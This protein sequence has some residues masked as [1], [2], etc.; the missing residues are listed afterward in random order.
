MTVVYIAGPFR[1]GTAWGIEQHIRKAEGLA[2]QVAQLGAMPMCPHTNTRFF[3]G[4]LTEQFWLD[5]TIE[6]MSRCDA[7][8][9]TDDWHLSIGARGEVTRAHQLNLPVLESIDAL[10]VWLMK[11]EVKS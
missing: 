11:G 1:D 2:Y 9:L 4:T 10:R 3:H 5:G 8:V 7:V 6:L